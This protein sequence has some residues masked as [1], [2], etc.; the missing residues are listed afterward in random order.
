MP[1]F[2]PTGDDKRILDELVRQAKTRRENTP[3]QIPS[4]EIE[5]DIQS[6]DTYIALP[7]VGGIPALTRAAFNEAAGDIPG[8]ADCDIY[9]IDRVSGELVKVS[10]FLEKVY[11]L[12]HSAILVEWILITK[13]KFGLWVV[14]EAPAITFKEG[15][16]TQTL[17]AATSANDGPTTA[18]LD[19]YGP[20]ITGTGG[21]ESTGEQ[22]TITNRLTEIE[23]IQSGAWLG[24]I[25]TN[26]EWR[27]V[28]ADCGISTVAV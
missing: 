25:Y 7:P 28:F 21:W 17:L 1:L 2:L 16:L 22:I 4:S 24:A 19:V 10:S 3:S 8:S 15:V 14:A 26:D 9:R 27:P 13:T 23:A 11:S 18:N 6:P 12:N 20:P 5:D